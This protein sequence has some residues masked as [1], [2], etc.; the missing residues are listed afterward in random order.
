[1]VPSLV[2]LGALGGPGTNTPPLRFYLIWGVASTA[3]LSVSTPAL[4]TWTLLGAG[5]APIGLKQPNRE[6]VGGFCTMVPGR[7]LLLGQ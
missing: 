7:G 1:M 5:L 3:L 2:V 6:H 4:G